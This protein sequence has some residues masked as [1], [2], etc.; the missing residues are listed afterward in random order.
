MHAL[1]YC[2][3]FAE[4]KTWKERSKHKIYSVFIQPRPMRKAGRKCNFSWSL[5]KSWLDV[6]GGLWSWKRHQFLEVVP[7]LPPQEFVLWKSGIRLPWVMWMS[8]TIK[9]YHGCMT[10]PKWLSSCQHIYCQEH[11]DQK[12]KIPR[13]QPC[14]SSLKS[15]CLKGLQ[16]LQ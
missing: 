12:S 11:S 14:I 1:F 9:R 16:S 8:T 4:F 5:D 15:L 2:T 7:A 6:I 13:L 3:H 10:Y